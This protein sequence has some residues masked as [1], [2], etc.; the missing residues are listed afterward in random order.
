ML[1]GLEQPTFSAVHAPREFVRNLP[2]Q[3]KNFLLDALKSEEPLNINTNCQMNEKIFFQDSRTKPD[4]NDNILLLVF[5]INLT[6]VVYNFQ[7]TT[8]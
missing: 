6:G 1:S 8:L 3:T 4:I 2:H 7:I 5:V